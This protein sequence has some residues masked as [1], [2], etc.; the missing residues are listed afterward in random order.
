MYAR[1]R[2]ELPIQNARPQTNR[3]FAF[4]TVLYHVVNDLLSQRDGSLS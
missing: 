1:E 3:I 4:P 2:W